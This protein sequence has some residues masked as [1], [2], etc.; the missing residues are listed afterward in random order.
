MVLLHIALNATATATN[1]VRVSLPHEIQNQT[2][3]LKKTIVEQ[4]YAAGGTNPSIIYV[5][6]GKW[7]S[8]YEVTSSEHV[9][10][11]PVSMDPGKDRTESDY[12]ISFHAETIPKEFDIKLYSDA[13]R[14]P[15][16]LQSATDH[17]IQHIS[18]LFEY[19]HN[20]QL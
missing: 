9:E 6:M 18:L 16:E 5:E 17:K 1:T 4:Q 15:L 12:H 7:L 20:H 2:L 3:T 19:S 10:Y 14:T 8:H 11:L 13:Q